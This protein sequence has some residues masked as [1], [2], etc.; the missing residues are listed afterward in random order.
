[1]KKYTILNCEG[2][3]LK[4]EIENNF[5]EIKF[6]FLAKMDNGT[7]RIHFSIKRQE[8]NDFFDSKIT[9]SQI[10]QNSKDETFLLIRYDKEYMVAKSE[11]INKIQCGNQ[12]YS[13]ILNDLKMNCT[14]IKRIL[15][16]EPL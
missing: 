7:G 5:Q 3:I 4:L 12:L 8:L 2:N 6:A 9:L 14:D 10:I 11:I 13:N 1:M 16:E 15:N